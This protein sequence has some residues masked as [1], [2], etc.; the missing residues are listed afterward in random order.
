MIQHESISHENELNSYHSL[1]LG[2]AH[3]GEASRLPRRSPIPVLLNLS[4]LNYEVSSMVNQKLA[5]PFEKPYQIFHIINHSLESP[6]I[7]SIDK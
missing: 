2:G 6:L 4:A 7:S 1:D 3:R 5:T